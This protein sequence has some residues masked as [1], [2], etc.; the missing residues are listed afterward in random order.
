MAMGYTLSE[1]GDAESM[2]SIVQLIGDI[3]GQINLLALNATIESARAREAGRGF[4]V[5]AA[6]GRGAERGD[7][8]NVDGYATGGGGGGQ[9]RRRGLI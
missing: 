8:R 2:R 5:V 4:A 1:I 3:T 7:R 6:R 9:D